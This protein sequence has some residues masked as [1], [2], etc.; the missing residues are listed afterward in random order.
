MCCRIM[1]RTRRA[2][3]DGVGLST[4]PDQVRRGLRAIGHRIIAPR[5]SNIAQQGLDFPGGPLA[6][7]ALQ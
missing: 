5:R 4:D 7:E 3:R 6:I 2:Q 1:P